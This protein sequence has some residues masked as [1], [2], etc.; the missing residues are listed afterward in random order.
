MSLGNNL[1][2]TQKYLGSIGLDGNLH[3]KPISTLSGGQKSR[4]VLA[5]LRSLNPHLLLLDEVSNHLDIESIE[6][7]IL[8]IN[9]FTGAVIMITHNIDV[10]EKTNSKILQ[11]DGDLEEILYDDYYDM[12]LNII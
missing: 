9:T 5:S 8:A 7:L 3:H 1:K 12:V 2:D 6:A 10:I 11:L 4:V